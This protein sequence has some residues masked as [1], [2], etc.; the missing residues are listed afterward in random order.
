[1]WDWYP[2]GQHTVNFS[3]LLEFQ[4][5]WNNSKDMVQNII[6]SLWGGTKGSWPCLMAKLSVVCLAWVYSLASAF[7]HFWWLNLFIRTWK[8]SPWKVNLSKSKKQEEDMGDGVFVL[9]RPHRVL[10]SYPGRFLYSTVTDQHGDKRVWLLNT[11]THS[12]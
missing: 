2:C 3:H 1:M 11:H 6:Y 10:L 5:L 12:S 4:Y 7:S 8:I 9:G